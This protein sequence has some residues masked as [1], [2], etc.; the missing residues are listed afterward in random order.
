ML[1]KGLFLVVGSLIVGACV[2]QPGA[3]QMQMKMIDNIGY[4]ASD[5]SKQVAGLTERVRRVERAMIRLDAR[6]KLIERN[7]LARFTA[8]QQNESNMANQQ[9][10]LQ[11]TSFNAS[12]DLVNFARFNSPFAKRVSS[13]YT[14][15]SLQPGI[16]T[17]SLQVAPKT[18][19]NNNARLASAGNTM[20][21]LPSIADKT[22]MMQE[23][24]VSIWTIE[25][26]SNKIWPTRDQLARSQE[27]VNLLKGSEPVAIFARGSNP[28]SKEFRER[29]RALSRY[30]GKIANSQNVAIATMPASHL[31]TDTIEVL[32]TK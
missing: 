32:V 15:T 23:K 6:M 26:S 27:V 10:K 28:S 19:M 12:N 31:D 8:V 5:N 11:E 4:Q 22:A 13:N 24:D 9:A 21:S 29:V 14:A 1:K 3:M 25:Y 2:P 20:T 30:L 18:Q 17:S 7:E 16:I